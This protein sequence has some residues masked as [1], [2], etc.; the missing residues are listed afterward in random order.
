MTER[1]SYRQRENLPV[2]TVINPRAEYAISLGDDKF[3]AKVK[4]QVGA[5]IGD[6]V[7]VESPDKNVILNALTV[8]ILPLICAFIAYAVSSGVFRADEK[9]SA[10]T[11]IG[12]VILC[13]AGIYL[14]SE[15]HKGVGDILYITEIVKHNEEKM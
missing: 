2:P 3:S 14:Y 6:T 1:L 13:F 4:N 8:F 9:I 5:V 11:A 15:F 10:L 12:A 7:T